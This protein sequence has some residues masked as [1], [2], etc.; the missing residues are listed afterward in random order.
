[1]VK[2]LILFFLGL[3]PFVLG[4]LINSWLMQNQNLV[5]PS[6]LIGLIFLSFWLLIGFATSEFE[7]TLLK[8]T[9]IVNLPAFLMLL[10]IMYQ[11]IILGHYWAN[12][13][14]I[15]AQFYYLPL[16]NI[17]S[18]VY[19]IF[20]FLTSGITYTRWVC[21]V[22]FLLMFASYYLGGYLKKRR[23]IWVIRYKQS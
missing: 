21:L 22:G 5:F 10:L 18:S 6:K 23:N 4:F 12:I 15:A 7:K 13:I 16:I 14:G 3:I 20:S 1:M 8:S 19:R 17:A 9:L 11:E 2:K